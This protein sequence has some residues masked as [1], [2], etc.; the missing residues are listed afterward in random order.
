MRAEQENINDV[1]SNSVSLTAEEEKEEMIVIEDALDDI[2]NSSKEDFFANHKDQKFDLLK[3]KLFKPEFEEIKRLLEEKI[4]YLN[5]QA[6]NS[7]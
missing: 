3:R 2:E 6:I 7:V 1:I 5:T 4:K